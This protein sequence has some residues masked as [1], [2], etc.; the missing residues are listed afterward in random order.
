MT[1][2]KK[3]TKPEIIQGIKQAWEQGV[4]L[5]TGAIQRGSYRWMY[6][7][8]HYYFSSWKATLKAADLSYKQVQQRVKEPKKQAYLKEL[9]QAYKQG[10]D[11]S[12]ISLQAKGNLN[13]GLYDRARTYY[14]GNFFWETALKEAGL[15]VKQI[16]RQGRWD[17]ER[18]KQ[19]LISR[20]NQ[21]K[22]LNNTAIRDEEYDLHKA[23]VKYFG[24]H[25]AAL[26]YA[27]F[28]PSEVR[29]AESHSLEEIILGIKR[30]NNK[31]VSLNPQKLKKGSDKHLKC[32]YWAG[33]KRFKGWRNAL[34]AA[35]V[36][37]S[38]HYQRKRWDKEKVKTKI[39]ELYEQGFELNPGS[40]LEANCDLY[41]AGARYFG[42]WR[43]TLLICK[44]DPETQYKHKV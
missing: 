40:V 19:R 15:P 13:R 12:A 10:I 4:D 11:L 34:T 3:H 38:K 6:R 44:I 35:G 17:K 39:L 16:V 31:G 27:G 18:V 41:K 24:S 36:D 26:R 1:R 23:T 22:P 5:R 9:N 29:K 37:P 42:S 30:Y 28:D 43:K 21:G 2:G 33:L 7:S 25:D 32:I 8:H 14:K 20:N